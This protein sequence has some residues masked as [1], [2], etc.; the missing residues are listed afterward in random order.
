MDST[1]TLEYFG[2]AYRNSPQINT[3]PNRVWATAF[4]DKRDIPGILTLHHTMRK[5]RTKYRLAVLV[6]EETQQ[7]DLLARFFKV[8]GITVITAA[9]TFPSHEIPEIQRQQLQMVAWSCINFERVILLSPTQLILKN[10][11]CLMDVADPSVSDQFLGHLGTRQPRPPPGDTICAPCTCTCL[12]TRPCVYNLS[13]LIPGA[14]PFELGSI[15]PI[16]NHTGLSTI[17][18]RPTVEMYYRLSSHSPPEMHAIE[19]ILNYRWRPLSWWF[20]A[21]LSFRQN[22]PEAWGRAKERRVIRVVNYDVGRRPWERGGRGEGEGEEEEWWWDA[23][24][25]VE[26]EW[27]SGEWKEKKWL[28]SKF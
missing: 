6:T 12:T 1:D 19:G 21:R 15:P 14:G 3:N 23:M 4:L 7:D 8:A 24:G 5:T 2:Q 13:F 17:V 22:H 16:L 28:W 20:D 27:T 25:E 9:L 18:L 26:G 11:D 10:I